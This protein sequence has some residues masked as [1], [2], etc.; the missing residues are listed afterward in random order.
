MKLNLFLGF[1]LLKT[2]LK[3]NLINLKLGSRS[4]Q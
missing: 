1:N 3:I 4:G 2:N